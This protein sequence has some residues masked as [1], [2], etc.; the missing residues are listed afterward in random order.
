[1]VFD[2]LKKRVFPT[3]V[4]LG[5]G[6]LKMAQLGFDGNQFFLHAAGREEKPKD[7]EPGSAVAKMGGVN[8]K[9]D[10]W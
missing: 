7:I 10:D 3:G 9:R 8:R 5:S 4:D 2:F 1:M 6:Y